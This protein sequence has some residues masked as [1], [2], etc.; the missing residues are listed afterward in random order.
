MASSCHFIAIV[1][2]QILWFCA[3]K[4]IASFECRCLEH[5]RNA[6]FVVVFYVFCGVPPSMGFS[7]RLYARRPPYLSKYAFCSRFENCDECLWAYDAMWCDADQRPT[8]STEDRNRIRRRA[9]R[10]FPNY[11]MHTKYGEFPSGFFGRCR[12]VVSSVDAVAQSRS[13]WHELWL[14]GRLTF[15]PATGSNECDVS[16][17]VL[18]QEMNRTWETNQHTHVCGIAS[19]IKLEFKRLE[20]DFDVR[21]GLSPV[22]HKEHAAVDTTN[23]LG[24]IGTYG[25]RMNTLWLHAN[26]VCVVA[27][28]SGL[29]PTF[30]KHNL[31]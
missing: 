28:I 18:E 22:G 15:E 14:F 17:L 6:F 29:R 1:C 4:W 10:S 19:G 30:C 16:C 7:L 3:K 20:F 31:C 11:V 21:M 27:F 13:V 12:K 25:G 24:R 5:S 23:G 26:E 8:S 9:G 2:F